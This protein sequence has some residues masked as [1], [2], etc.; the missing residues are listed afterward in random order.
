MGFKTFGF[1]GGRADVW[2]RTSQY[3]GVQRTTGWGA[4]YV[5]R[6][7]HPAFKDHAY[8]Y[9]D[10]DADGDI[11]SRKLENHLPPCRWADLCQPGRT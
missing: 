10:D 9:S 6:M 7:V 8:W 3:T 1:A 11:H 4:T 5:M 2:R